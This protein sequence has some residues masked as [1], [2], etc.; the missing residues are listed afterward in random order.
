M[1][2]QVI[3]FIV[4]ADKPMNFVVFITAFMLYLHKIGYFYPGIRLF[5]QKIVDKVEYGFLM[6]QV[7][8]LTSAG[9]K[10][11]TVRS[12]RRGGRLYRFFFL[13]FRIRGRV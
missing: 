12:G 7:I 5:C 3:S 13:F 4:F 1:I 11:V 10:H 6:F 8:I 9:D 2:A